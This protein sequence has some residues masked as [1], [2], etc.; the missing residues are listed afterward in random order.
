M[1]GRTEV[2]EDPP[3]FDVTGVLGN[4]SAALTE[5]ILNLRI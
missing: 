2:G 3:S 1:E 5:A 4:L